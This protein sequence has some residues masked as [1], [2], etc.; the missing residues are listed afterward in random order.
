MVEFSILRTWRRVFRKLITLDFKRT[1]FALCKDLLD[2]DL[3]GRNVANILE[4]PQELTLP[5]P[6]FISDRGNQ[7]GKNA[8]RPAW[9]NKKIL[10]KLKLKKEVC[11]QKCVIWKEYISE[12]PEMELGKLRYN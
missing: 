10:D 8:G 6:G 3:W 11:K 4:S 9:M 5:H 7:L 2:K 1:E 12:H